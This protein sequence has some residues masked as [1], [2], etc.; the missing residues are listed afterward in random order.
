MLSWRCERLRYPDSKV[1][2]VL[3]IIGGF[4]PPSSTKTV[5]NGNAEDAEKIP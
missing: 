1:N 2:T 4:F 5:R 3:M